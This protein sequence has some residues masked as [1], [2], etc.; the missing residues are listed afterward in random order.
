MDRTIAAWQHPATHNR[1]VPHAVPTA[2]AGNGAVGMSD[3]RAPQSLVIVFQRR[4][5][6]VLR[7]RGQDIVLTPGSLV[8]Y[9]AADGYVHRVD[10]VADCHRLAVPME[11]IG[12]TAEQVERISGVNLREHTSLAPLLQSVV[13]GVIMSGLTLAEE[14]TL[15]QPVSA[16]LRAAMISALCG[17][18][19]DTGRRSP[20][21]DQIVRYTLDHLSDAGLG[22]AQISRD[23]HI[24]ERLLY[25]E[26]ARAGIRLA[27]LIQ[28]ERLN[29]TR[30]A[31]EAPATAHVP[32]GVLAQQNGFVSASHFSRVFR[33]R[34]GLTP[35]EWRRRVTA[36]TIPAV[37]RVAEAAAPVTEVV[38]AVSATAAAS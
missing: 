34:F 19:V 29:R 30:D 12:L 4:S 18:G 13:Q 22:A 32:I 3:G 35:R 36:R 37:Q 15:L 11:S 1:T 23:L 2:P 17:I 8:A 20:L 24:S 25:A 33:E 14:L 5:T 26:M 10:D 7:R 9:P 27:A 6:S 21:A 38:N 31:L 16:L 28:S